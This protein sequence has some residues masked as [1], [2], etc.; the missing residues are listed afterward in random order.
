MNIISAKAILGELLEA[1]E[2]WEHG[3]YFYDHGGE[4]CE[5]V[6]CILEQPRW[7]SVEER[8][9]EKDKDVM[10]Y[11]NKNGGHMF[12]GYRGWISG[13]WMEGGSL[14]IGDVTHWMSLPSAPEV[15]IT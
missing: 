10:C 15:E 11:S 12:F 9:P 3:D 2:A 4:V 13:E 8:L 6:E 5:A 7:I 1:Y 14:H